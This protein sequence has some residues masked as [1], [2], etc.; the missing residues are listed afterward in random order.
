MITVGIACARARDSHFRRI[1]AAYRDAAGYITTRAPRQRMADAQHYAITFASH[2]GVE[3]Q[4]GKVIF[5]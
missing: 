2:S 5:Q 4:L 1:S 3:H